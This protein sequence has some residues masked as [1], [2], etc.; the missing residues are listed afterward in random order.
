MK[1]SKAKQLIEEKLAPALKGRVTYTV[2]SY[3]FAHDKSGRANLTVDG[4]DIFNL[5]KETPIHWYPTVQ[6]AKKDASVELPVYETE[7]ESLRNQGIPEDRIMM[8][9]RKRKLAGWGDAVFKAQTALFKTDFTKEAEHFL[10]CSLEQA[11]DSEEILM[12]IFALL[13]GRLGKKRLRNMEQKMKSK[14]PAV[15]YFYQLR[16]EAEK[17]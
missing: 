15:Q 16:C 1:W 9:A 4:V 11:L 14:H 13:D 8:V 17:L 7:M 5:A 10:S 2:S 6:D 12:N 3:R